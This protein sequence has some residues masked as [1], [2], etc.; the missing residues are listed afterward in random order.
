MRHLLYSTQS[1]ICST[2]AA[3]RPQTLSSHFYLLALVLRELREHLTMTVKEAIG[4]GYT[5]LP[6]K[7]P[8]SK[9][10]DPSW[11][12]QTMYCGP[13]PTPSTSTPAPRLIQ[14]LLHCWPT[15]YPVPLLSAHPKVPNTF[16]PLSHPTNPS[17]YVPPQTHSSSQMSH[18]SL[19]RSTRCY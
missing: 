3:A 4:S 5:R 14:F 11:A 19:Q 18:T 9:A 8:S 7:L 10:V 6:Q 15:P 2:R 12:G 16:H 17:T 13:E 1:L